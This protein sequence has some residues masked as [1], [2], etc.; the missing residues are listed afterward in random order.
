MATLAVGGRITES[1][2]VSEIVRLQ[3]AWSGFQA[4]PQSQV[5][6]VAEVL[7]QEQLVELDL[8]DRLQLNEVIKV[9]RNSR[10]LAEAGRVL[11]NASREKKSST[12][13]S[14]RVKQYLQ[15]F[16]L[17]FASVVNN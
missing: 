16:G 9:C 11:F 17:S 15:K 8:F 12:N 10:S 5:D 6:L 14:H 4:S 2:V 3:Q 1:I 13:D 7:S